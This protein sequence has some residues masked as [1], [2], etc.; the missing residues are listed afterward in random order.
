M[1]ECDI[2]DIIKCTIGSIPELTNL[3]INQGTNIQKMN[4]ELES[5]DLEIHNLKLK[6]EYKNGE[7]ST[8]KLKIA[9]K[10]P[11]DTGT[12][13]PSSIEIPPSPVER[14]PDTVE[15][16]NDPLTLIVLMQTRIDDVELAISGLQYQIC[17]LQNTQTLIDKPQESINEL[18]VY[19]GAQGLKGESI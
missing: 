15:I 7:I 10:R 18:N 6:I 13:S 14:I 16:N 19:I 9:D 2:K 8:L 3:T 4:D 1:T 17:E 12:K 11:L 5:K